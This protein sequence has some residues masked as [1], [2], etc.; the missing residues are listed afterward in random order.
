MAGNLARARIAQV[1]AAAALVSAMLMLLVHVC[2]FGGGMGAAYQTCDCRGIEWE[3]YD[4]TPA[5]G[6]RKT[7]CLGMVASRTCFQ[8]QSGPEIPCNP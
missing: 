3:I 2:A 7:L 8:L 6:P 1:F 5:D 4:H